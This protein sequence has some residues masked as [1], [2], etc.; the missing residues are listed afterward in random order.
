[1]SLPKIEI[2]PENLFD[3]LNAKYQTF[4]CLDSNGFSDHSFSLSKFEKLYAAGVHDEIIANQN[5]LPA[6]QKFIDKHKGKWILGYL[7]FDLKNEIEKLSSVNTDKFNRPLVHFFVPETVVKINNCIVSKF[8]YNGTKDNGKEVKDSISQKKIE[9]DLL[10]MTAASPNVCNRISKK[11]YIDKIAEIK[12]HIQMGDIYELTLCQ[13]FFAENISINPVSVFKEMKRISPSPFSCFLKT[14][15]QYLLSSSPERFLCRR[16][17]KIFSQPIK[18]TSKRGSNKKEDEMLKQ[19]LFESE[20]ERSENVM[21][22]DLVRNDLSKIAKRGS[23]KVDEL[24]GIYSYSTVHQ[25]ISTVSCECKEEVS[26][27]DIIKAT[28]PMGSMT[29]A[30]KIRA[31]QLIEEYEETG[32]G[33]FSGAVG[34]IDPDGDFDFSVVIRSILYD[35][36]LKY[37]SVQTGG[38]I[39]INSVAENEYEESVLKSKT[40]LTALNNVTD[41]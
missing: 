41:K 11:K 10:E 38:A 25:M 5:A 8:S 20:K 17:S 16:G 1:M 37:I 40:M 21:I 23:V 4:I 36:S 12:N 39:T 15:H 22:V 26:F 9:T 2:I 3:D 27:A 28:F 7:S 14:G 6:L 29:G 24:F 34:Y 35:S 13:E 31:L 18:G 30:P 33:L 32:R 19:Q